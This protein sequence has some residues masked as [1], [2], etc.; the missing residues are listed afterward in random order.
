MARFARNRETAL[1]ATIYFSLGKGYHTLCEWKSPFR[2]GAAARRAASGSHGSA[3][4]LAL[5]LT[6]S[7]V[8]FSLGKGI[9]EPPRG[10][11][12]TLRVC[13]WPD[14]TSIPSCAFV[15]PPGSVSQRASWW[16]LKTNQPLKLARNHRGEPE[17]GVS[18][19]GGLICA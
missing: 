4:R 19:A 2:S 12:S 16:L 10:T 13:E 8:G 5:P 9:I 7:L 17:G 3:G 6:A 15:R 14:K 18:P 11:R 1:P